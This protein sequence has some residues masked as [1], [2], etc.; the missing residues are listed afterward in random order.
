[1]DKD[2]LDELGEEDYCEAVFGEGR[3]VKPRATGAEDPPV[4]GGGG[5]LN[6]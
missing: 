4:A 6:R 5:C 3:S 1:M 2:D